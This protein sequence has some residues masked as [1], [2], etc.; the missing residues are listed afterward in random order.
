LSAHPSPNPYDFQ[1]QF[2]ADR[3]RRPPFH[4]DLGTP[5]N[6]DDINGYHH[7]S[8]ASG[9]VCRHPRVRGSVW[10]LVSLY[11]G[12]LVDRDHAD[13]VQKKVLGRLYRFA[14]RG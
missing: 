7:R 12:H 13:I 1:L 5:R 9:N 4:V 2:L 14:H 3:P 10:L 6:P 8:I 11:G